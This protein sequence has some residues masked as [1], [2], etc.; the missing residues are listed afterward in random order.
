MGPQGTK[1]AP[2]WWMATAYP[3]ASSP[4]YAAPDEHGRLQY[5]HL[6]ADR[7]AHN[8]RF[9]IRP[10]GRYDL[11][12][13]SFADSPQLFPAGL[14]AEVQD[15][16]KPAQP[17]PLAGGL[18]VV[19]DRTQPIEAPLILS[20]TRLDKPAQPGQPVPPGKIWEVIIAQ[21]TEQAI[22]ERNQTL[23]RQLAY[24]HV[25]FT[26]LRRLTRDG[27]DED[28]ACVVKQWD[29]EGDYKLPM[30]S[31][32]QETPPPIPS[33]YPAQPD[34][35]SLGNGAGGEGVDED[36]ARSL[37]LPAR[38][39][40]FQQGALALQWQDLPFYYTHR[41]L[42]VA[43][44]ANTVSPVN[45]VEQS[46][47]EYRTPQP[48]GRVSGQRGQGD[49]TAPALR[50]RQVAIPLCS[51]WESLP[52]TAQASWPDERPD[53]PGSTADKRKFSSLPD[54]DVVYQI[55]EQFSGNTEVQV[56]FFYDAANKNYG[57][58]QLG[59]RY[60]GQIVG[61]LAPPTAPPSPPDGRSLHDPFVLLTAINQK[62]ETDAGP[63][64]PN[65]ADYSEEAVA[66]DLSAD[67]LV[68]FPGQDNL[69]STEAKAVKLV[70]TGNMSEAE[71]AAVLAVPGEQAFTRRLA[72]LV[73]AVQAKPAPAPDEAT[74][75]LAPQN[76]EP[77]PPDVMN[78]EL[79]IAPAIRLALQRATDGKSY[80]AVV[81]Q[82]M[83][84]DDELV[85][86]EAAVA[87]W[88]QTPEVLAALDQVRTLLDERTLSAPLPPATGGRPTQED[89]REAVRE[90]L[91]IGVEA[92]TWQGRLHSK[93][94]LDALDALAAN[95]NYDAGFL[96]A[97]GALKGQLAQ[98]PITV[99]LSPAVPLRPTQ[100]ELPGALADKLLLGSWRLGCHGIL[101]AAEGQ[102]LLG[103][104]ATS[105]A[106][107]QAIERLYA[108]SLQQGLAGRR[109]LIRAARQRRA[110]RRQWRWRW[111]R[112]QTPAPCDEAS[113]IRGIGRI[114]CVRGTG[115][116]AE[117][118]KYGYEKLTEPPA[119]MQPWRKR[120][121][122][123]VEPKN[124]PPAG[125]YVL[126][127][128]RPALDDK[129]F[130]HQ[131][132][133]LDEQGRPLPGIR[134]VVAYS[135][136]E[137]ISLPRHSDWEH[138][139]TDLRGKSYRTDGSG[140]ASHPT[141]KTGGERIW[142]W[143][144]DDDGDLKLA[145]IKVQGCAVV[146]ED[147]Y[148]NRGVHL[149]FQR[150]KAEHQPPPGP[151]KQP[152]LVIKGPYWSAEVQLLSA[153]VPMAHAASS[154][155]GRLLFVHR[156]PRALAGS[157]NVYLPGT[158]LVLCS[159]RSVAI[160]P[161]AGF[162]YRWQRAGD[163]LPDV[164]TA[165]ALQAAIRTGSAALLVVRGDPDQ[166]ARGELVFECLN[167][168]ISLDSLQPQGNALENFYRA[169][170]LQQAG[171][172]V[173][174]FAQRRAASVHASGVSLYAR[175][176]L[177]WEAQPLALPIQIARQF[178]T[179]DRP[180]FRLSLETDRL[181]AGEEDQVARA[182]RRLSGYVNPKHPLNEKPASPLAFTPIWL[183]LELTN[184]RSAPR[185]FSEIDTWKAEGAIA[186]LQVETGEIS[187]LISDQQ[188]YDSAN[189]AVSLARVQSNQTLIR[190][191]GANLQITVQ[192]KSDNPAGKGAIQYI[193]ERAEQARRS[194]LA[195]I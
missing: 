187:L 165:A 74:V 44:T 180:D 1:D 153:P 85:D 27:W 100:E 9:Y 167:G 99:E 20:S 193:W 70:W 45:R 80:T 145:S 33:S 61:L 98:T 169:V 179:A 135:D 42:V 12:W 155:L 53:G 140:R 63:D 86:F 182:W 84:T 34:H 168:E 67:L 111:S 164:K 154:P 40:V 6:F 76:L 22:V 54:P 25:A 37:A 82:G 105:G 60:L 96:G 113:S 18:D 178:P 47:F 161:A 116:S 192:A 141:G 94:Q 68:L 181:T 81:W 119:N 177:P 88:T 7:W 50:F 124:V 157:T 77:I 71:K 109:L 114:L 23:A 4:A 11:I 121:L 28:L 55:V 163:T 16:L 191:A 56:E 2:L 17:D 190:K 52:P 92:L 144:I 46:N 166:V 106:D 31:V 75:V 108:A 128:C 185:F 125:E 123:F 24:R 79:P 5:D 39:G 38:I 66:R 30:Q 173:P 172:P 29:G 32:S 174:D 143:D 162:T 93:E 69:V 64:A 122:R 183:T 127:D 41:L 186:D 138:G 129:E 3:R 147:R 132:L 15:E 156:Q 112:W 95:T 26:L 78:T 136:G 148:H 49:G 59:K 139:E 118:D 10:Y 8:Y 152:E 89:M 14:P 158:L 120:H 115:M 175:I 48:L 149:T 117:K 189:P 151:G 131:V 110:Q 159:V 73:A 57:V 150:R 170:G 97:V 184:P 102:A 195:G 19:L 134:I 104:F 160:A 62:P 176:Q 171:A 133:V 13:R 142:V 87:G 101:T 72:E 21:H 65:A 103:L 83:L 146:N 51:F 90:Q 137:P 58:R 91:L 194:H 188:P 35:I 126:I 43:Q 107:R 130:Q 36:E